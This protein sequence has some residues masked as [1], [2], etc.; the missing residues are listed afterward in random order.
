MQR[1][2]C[3][4]IFDT[5]TCFPNGF[6]HALGKLF[7]QTHQLAQ[8]WIQRNERIALCPAMCLPSATYH[9][10]S[11]MLFQKSMGHVGEGIALHT[12]AFCHIKPL[13]VPRKVVGT[14]GGLTS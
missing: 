3:Y 1:E 13:K 5:L 7:A 4:P 12:R 9:V 2:C 8:H 6:Q 10:A 11:T 14:H